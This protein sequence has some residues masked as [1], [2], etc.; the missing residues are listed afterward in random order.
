ML[1][2]TKF[3]IAFVLGIAAGVAIESMIDYAYGI[4]WK[5]PKP[6]DF[7]IAIPSLFS[8]YMGFYMFLILSMFISLIIT[9]IPYLKA[10]FPNS[11]YIPK[12]RDTT[13]IPFIRG[14]TFGFGLMIIY[15]L[16]TKGIPKLFG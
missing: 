7:Y 4:D 11:K 1:Q 3:L 12:I 14:V 9:V 6:I 5:N 13:V 15:H 10:K 16:F 2:T 8:G